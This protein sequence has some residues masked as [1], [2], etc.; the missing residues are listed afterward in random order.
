VTLEVKL[1]A[2]HIRGQPAVP[3]I[4]KGVILAQAVNQA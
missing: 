3:D 2:M 4:L 1:I